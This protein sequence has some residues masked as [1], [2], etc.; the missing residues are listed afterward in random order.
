M[1]RHILVV[2]DDEDARSLVVDALTEHGF[3]VSEAGDGQA[4]MNSVDAHHPDL[5]VLDLGLPTVGGLEVL[6]I[7]RSTGDLPVII[8]SGRADNTD[9]IVGLEL[10]AD[11]YVAKPFDPREVVARVNAVLR[12]GRSEQPDTLLDFGDI[13]I[14]LVTHDVTCAG[15]LVD[16]T[17]KEFDLL[18]FMAKSPRQVFS[19]EQL[20]DNVWNSSTNWQDAST[21]N[22]HIHRLRRKIE[23]DITRPRWISTL[24]GA[25][26]RFT[27]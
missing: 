5:V 2:D 12:R 10:G 23:P 24:R 20:L 13:T 26:Y 3:R 22:E 4:A 27:P 1:T 17:A 7:I 21:V 6:K 8:L 11:D 19:R 15:E 16:L 25:G 18:A 14:D 9:R